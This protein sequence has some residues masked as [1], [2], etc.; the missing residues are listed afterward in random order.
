MAATIKDV[1][2]KANVSISTVSRVLSNQMHVSS[3]TYKR[4][5]DAVA[6]LNYIPNSSAVSL[7]KKSSTTVLYADSFYKGRPYE[8]PH[9]FDIIS[10]SSHEL[11]KKGYF[12]GLLDLDCSK[13]KAEEQ[14]INAI[15]S[16]KADGI[17]INGYY[18][19]PA[20][21]KILLATDFPHICIGKP[22]FDSMLSWIDT[23]HSLSSNLAITHLVSL[24]HKKIAFVGATGAGKTTITNLINRFYDIQSGSVTYDGI[25]VRDIRKDSLRRSLGIVLQDTHLFTGTIADNI[26]YGKLDATDEEVRAAARLANADTFIRHLPQG[27]DTVLYSDGANLSQGQRQLVAIARA[28]VSRAPVL[29]LDEATSSIDT[30]TEI[31]IQ[32]AFAAMMEGRTSFIVAHR[33]STIQEADL[34]LVMKDGNIIE[35]GRHEELLAKK[36][37]YANLYESQFAIS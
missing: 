22:S 23:N 20:I 4:I 14:I 29:I 3:S 15:Q 13:E 33:L 1:A 26:R 11:R 30:R 36:G 9:M 21:E 19:T 5:Q 6:E 31:R 7:V 34:I 18:V 25:D 32:K 17:L 16:K 28:A 35:Q 12:L 10:G 24:G 8:N 27:Y 2:K 37:F